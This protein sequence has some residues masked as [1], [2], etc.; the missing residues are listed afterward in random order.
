MKKYLPYI[1]VGVGL[2][3]LV[4]V[5]VVVKLKN[6]K[7]VEA[8]KEKTALIELSDDKKPIVSLKPSEDGHYLKLKIEKLNFGA[9][10]MDYELVYQAKDIQQGVPGTVKIEGKDSFE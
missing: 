7:D 3:I 4:I 2:L 8:P 6:K 1:L 10:S 9:D 5:F